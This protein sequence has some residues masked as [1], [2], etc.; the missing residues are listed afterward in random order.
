LE[1]VVVLVNLKL[2]L[3]EYFQILILY[4]TVKIRII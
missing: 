4:F 3:R 2:E 1:Q